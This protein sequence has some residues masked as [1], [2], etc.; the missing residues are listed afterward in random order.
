[1]LLCFPNLTDSA[2][3]TSTTA[4]VSTLPLTNLQDRRLSKR[5]RTDA[6]TSAVLT[7]DLGAAKSIWGVALAGHNLSV[8][9]TIRVRGSTASSFATTEYDSGIVTAWPGITDH[10]EADG[11]VGFSPIMTGAELA[12]CRYWRIDVAD[13][14]NLDGFL[15]FGR[16]FIG[17]GWKPERPPSFGWS[18]SYEDATVIE[19]SLGGVEYFDERPQ[20]RVLTTG[21]DYLTPAEFQG[22]AMAML[23]QGVAGELM[24]IFDETDISTHVRQSFIG[25]LRTL[26][27]IE[28]PDPIRHSTA[29][30]VREAIA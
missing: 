23:R 22:Q 28:N 20:V 14:M 21:L 24:M 5:A 12:N 4:W 3:I 9:A 26:S 2:T 25:R 30:E 13:V 1:M 29:I 8:T 7:L 11:F 15:E 10:A 16:V 17:A 19:S 18:L 6:S 27:P